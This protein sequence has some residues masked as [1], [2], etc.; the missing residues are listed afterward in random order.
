[1]N[2]MNG[3]AP[4]GKIEYPFADILNIK[5]AKSCGLHLSKKIE[6]T[7]EALGLH[8]LA[9]TEIEPGFS[10]IARLHLAASMKI[11]SLAIEFTELSQL[12]ENVLDHNIEIIAGCVKVLDGPG[13]GVGLNEEVFEK[14]RLDR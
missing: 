5:I 7:A 13:F 8:C 2:E 4:F 3:L 6:T 1:M 12:K 11:H 10:L 9:G 14:V